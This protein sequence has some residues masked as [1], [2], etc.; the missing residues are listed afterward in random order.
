[1][2]MSDNEQ[3]VWYDC[4]ASRA[5]KCEPC[6]SGALAAIHDD[7]PRNRV[8]SS[9]MVIFL[10]RL[11][12]Q[13]RVRSQFGPRTQTTPWGFWADSKNKPKQPRAPFLGLQ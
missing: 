8:E 5:I 6:I 9:I 2:K 4:M 12:K 3:I 1:M 7:E 11:T 13:N 10:S